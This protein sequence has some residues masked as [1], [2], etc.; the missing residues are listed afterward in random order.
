VSLAI[1]LY[2]SRLVYFTTTVYFYG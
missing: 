2:S 1:S